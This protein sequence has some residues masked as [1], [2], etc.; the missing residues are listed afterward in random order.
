MK[1]LKSIKVTERKKKLYKSIYIY[2][3]CA[4]TIATLGFFAEN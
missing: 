2:C 4:I 3:K 1:H